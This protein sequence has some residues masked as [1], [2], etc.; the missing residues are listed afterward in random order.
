[1]ALRTL[2][3]RLPNLR[4]SHPDGLRTAGTIMRGPERLPVTFD[5]ATAS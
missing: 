1:V 5:P 3:T 2:L 4:L